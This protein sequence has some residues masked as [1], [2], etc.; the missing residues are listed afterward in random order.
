MRTLLSKVPAQDISWTHQ[1]PTYLFTK[2]KVLVYVRISQHNNL[3]TEAVDSEV[4]V[5]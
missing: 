4:S 5:A 3:P 2:W 1:E